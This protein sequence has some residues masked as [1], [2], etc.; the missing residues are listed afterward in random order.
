MGLKEY[1]KNDSM[2]TILE[3]QSN[4]RNTILCN[5]LFQTFHIRRTVDVIAASN[6]HISKFSL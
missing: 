6:V 5:N 4:S 2:Y 1:A 3:S